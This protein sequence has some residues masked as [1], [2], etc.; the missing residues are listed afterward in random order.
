M[1]PKDEGVTAVCSSGL[2]S[3]A[4]KRV[5]LMVTDKGKCVKLDF[6]QNNLK[7]S[8]SSPELGDAKE[9]LEIQY[10]GEP[11]SVGFNARYV[12]DIANSLG[13]EQNMAVE[14]HGT[15]GPGKFFAEGDTS[16]IG[17]VMPM[18]LM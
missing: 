2:L 8:S 18:R 17:I 9:E 14:L 5:A 15:L 16:Y 1:L 3:Q 7:I 4:L 12:V 13:E 10:D 11:L 6:T